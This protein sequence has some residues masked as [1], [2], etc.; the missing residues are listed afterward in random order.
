MSIKRYD[1]Q[2]CAFPQTLREFPDGEYVS[3]ADHEAEVSRLERQHKLMSM[4][5]V[6][7]EKEADDAYAEIARL[8][9]E[10]PGTQ[11]ETLICSC[12]EH[13]HSCSEQQVAL[14]EEAIFLIDRLEEY[15]SGIWSEDHEREFYGHVSPSLARLRQIV[16]PRS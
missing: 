12:S 2:H 15:E 9:G 4:T 16:R 7:A 13:G 14:E 11:Q 10:Q 1:N 5:A 3:F 6:G 8:K